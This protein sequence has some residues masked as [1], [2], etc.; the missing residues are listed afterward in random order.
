MRNLHGL[1]LNKHSPV[2]QMVRSHI[3][4]LVA[5]AGALEESD[6][7][8]M[9]RGSAAFLAQALAGATYRAPRDERAFTD[10]TLLRICHFIEGQLSQPE[11]SPDHIARACAVSRATLYRLFEPFGGVAA[12]VRRQRLLRAKRDLASIALDGQTISAI[13]RRNGFIDD[14][15]FRRAFRQAFGVSAR[16]VRA[17]RT[18]GR[19]SVL[20]DGKIIS[21][22]VR[23][24]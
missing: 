5:A 2:G 20:A 8:A 24:L 17:H 11:L 13:A 19:A 10:V 23:D 12:Y 15:S 6:V 1:V 22:W 18:A 4:A 7:E 21:D 16:D 3:R 14:A 9:G